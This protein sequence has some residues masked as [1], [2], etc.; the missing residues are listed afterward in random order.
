MLGLDLRTVR[1]VWTV[2]VFAGALAILYLLRGVLLLL[3]SAVVFAYLL[4]PLVQLAQSW[5]VLRHRRAV[6]IGLVY[7][8]L[9]AVLTTAGMVV[10]PRFTASQPALAEKL[11]EVSEQ[12]Q[13]GEFIGKL[14]ERRGWDRARIREVEDFVR[15]HAAAVITHV[16]RAAGAVLTWLTGAWVIVLVPI[17]A[18]F[19]LKDGDR[20][21]ATVESLMQSRRW[22]RLWRDILGDLHQLLGQYVRALILLC[23][24]TF[25]VWATVFLTAGVPFAIP[26]AVLGGA[27]EFIPVVGPVA[28]GVIV[29]TVGFFAGY[30]HLVLLLIFLIAWRLIQDY[31]TSPLVM[32][33]GVEMHP[34]LVIFGVIAGGEI[35]GVAGMFL[36]VPVIAAARMIWRRVDAFRDDVSS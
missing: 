24:I 16:Q 1:I 22:R 23:C 27:L 13:S 34:A 21:A 11:P 32:G 36:S 28:A 35:A 6:A 15:S 10:G 29:M 31:V 8:V 17:F 14:L 30:S 7:L 3:V 12:V 18:F 25:V 9:L 26:L 2:I 33:S 5:T 4:V 19:F 20:F